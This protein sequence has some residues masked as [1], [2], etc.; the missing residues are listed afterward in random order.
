[1]GEMRDMT[2]AME[3]TRPTGDT[4]EDFVRMMM[5]HHQA[6]IAMA[7]TELSYGRDPE[8]KVMADAIVASQGQE[9]AAM[10]AWLAKH[11]K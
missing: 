8:L 7:K 9:L 2:A 1:M 5:P 11:A 4:D 10:K 3:H 6:A